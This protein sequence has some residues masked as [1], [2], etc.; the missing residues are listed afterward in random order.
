MWGKSDKK[1]LMNDNI[2][3]SDLF[4]L[5]GYNNIMAFLSI[6]HFVELVVNSYEFVQ[7]FCLFHAICLCLSDVNV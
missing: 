1:N 5:W 2:K 6:L 3:Q 4:E 7:S